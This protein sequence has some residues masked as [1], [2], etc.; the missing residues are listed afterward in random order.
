MASL[1]RLATLITISFLLGLASC[2]EYEHDFDY[3]GYDCKFF[4]NYTDSNCSTFQLDHCQ[5]TECV[6]YYSDGNNTY[7]DQYQDFTNTNW[8][9]CTKQCCDDSVTYP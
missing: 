4:L 8:D 9:T 7:C 6:S 1:K 3:S 2:C 5:W